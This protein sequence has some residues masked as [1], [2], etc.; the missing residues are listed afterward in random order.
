MVAPRETGSDRG[1]MTD[2]DESLARPSKAHEGRNESDGS[3]VMAA[4]VYL[5]GRRY[6]LDTSRSG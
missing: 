6:F 1:E 4:A 2:D 5:A 3:L